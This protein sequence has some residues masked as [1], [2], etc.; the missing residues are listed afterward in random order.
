[1]RT[2]KR[3]SCDECAQKHVRSQT[4]QTS[5]KREGHEER[6][7]V[8]LDFLGR[9][10]EQFPPRVGRSSL[11]KLEYESSPCRHRTDKH[12]AYEL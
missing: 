2:S 10:D 9:A 11:V 6:L 3:L 7:T 12:R 5:L 8:Q 4:S 1:M